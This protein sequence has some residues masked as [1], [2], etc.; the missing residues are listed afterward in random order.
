MIHEVFGA[1][2]GKPGKEVF[3]NLIKVIKKDRKK[4]ARKLAAVDGVFARKMDSIVS[5]MASVK[6][7]MRIT[8]LPKDY[9]DNYF[10]KYG[11]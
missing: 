10:N 7:R 6:R 2:V 8:D 5:S 4:A 3:Q 1:E 9:I 11:E